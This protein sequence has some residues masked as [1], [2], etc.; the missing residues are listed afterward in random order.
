MDQGILLTPFGEYEQLFFLG[1]Q[2]EEN[3]AYLPQHRRTFANSNSL[4]HAIEER[5][6]AEIKW[7]EHK[8]INWA[9]LENE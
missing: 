2:N 8:H 3:Q 4:D 5:A 7:N 9:E 1:Y 6:E